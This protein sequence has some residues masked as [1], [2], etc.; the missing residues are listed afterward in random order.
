[1]SFRQGFALLLKFFQLFVFLEFLFDLGQIFAAG[2][3]VFSCLLSFFPIANNI[4]SELAKMLVGFQ[5]GLGQQGLLHLYPV[6][7]FLGDIP[8]LAQK[9][10][11]DFKDVYF[12]IVFDRF[13][14]S[15]ANKGNMSRSQLLFEVGRTA[16]LSCGQGGQDLR[17]FLLEIIIFR[18][19]FV[20]GDSQASRHFQIVLACLGH[21]DRVLGALQRQPL[22]PD[23]K[24]T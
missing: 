8:L 9:I 20:N 22:Y 1:M 7:R 11:Q 4:I 16:I 24:Q 21:L 3:E 12:N 2:I 6:S 13:L 19:Q 17:P 14:G 23:G 15:V 10:G 18:Q 5:F